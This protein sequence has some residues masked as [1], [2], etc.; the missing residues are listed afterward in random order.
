MQPYGTPPPQ[1]GYPPPGYYGPQMPPPKRGMSGGMIALIVVGCLFGGCVMCGAIGA[2]SKK[3]Q[4]AQAQ[5]T[6]TG[7]T[8]VPGAKATPEPRTAPTPTEKPKPQA[9]LVTA[10]QLFNDYQ[11]N[12]VSADDK[13]KGKTL[14]VSGNVAEVKKDFTDSIIIGLRSPNQ[15]MPIDAHVEDSEKSKAGRLNKGDA[16]KLRCEGGG[17]IIGRPQLTDCTV[18]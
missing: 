11:G 3:D 4:G 7:T 2:S 1:G 13:Y 12:E 5:A 16:V 15:F 10:T 14:L 9:V 6:A 18:E 8:R 17:M